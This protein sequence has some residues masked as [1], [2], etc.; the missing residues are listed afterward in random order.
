[1]DHYNSQSFD[2]VVKYFENYTLDQN[3]P[4]SYWIGAIGLNH[5]DDDGNLK[6]EMSFEPPSE[7][8]MYHGVH[9][10]YGFQSLQYLQERGLFKLK[11]TNYG[12][13]SKALEKT[14]YGNTLKRRSLNHR[15]QYYLGTCFRGRISEDRSINRQFIF[16]DD[17]YQTL[18]DEQKIFF[19]NSKIDLESDSG[20][21]VYYHA[22]KGH[23]ILQN[24]LKYGPRGP[25]CASVKDETLN[26][27]FHPGSVRSDV[28][29]EADFDDWDIF[30]Y[31]PHNRIDGLE[32]STIEQF[33]SILKKYE[34]LKERG[35]EV[36]EEPSRPVSLLYTE[37]R[38]ETSPKDIRLEGFREEVFDWSQ[39]IYDQFSGKPLSVYIGHDKSHRSGNKFLSDIS[40]KSF[41]DI[42]HKTL[43]TIYKPFDIKKLDVSEIPEYKRPYSNQS[44]EFTYS[45]FLVPF[46]ENYTGYSM[47]F[48]DDFI[49][50]K[51]PSI[52]FY[53]VDP[54]VAVS[55]VQYPEMIFSETKFNGQQNVNY[56]KKLWSSLMIF[57]NSHPDCKILTPEIVNEKS[58]SWLHQFE[59][60]EKVGNI[61]LKYVHTEG[62]SG[63]SVDKDCLLIHY[64]RGGPWI[65]NMD[66]SDIKNLSYFE[67]YV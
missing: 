5:F 58:G 47:F 48:D 42:S 14:S 53:W 54:D 17:V 40:E 59:W 45:R 41:R 1:M 26:I 36:V 4:D 24:A 31:D 2:E 18:T 61:P 60:T 21:S 27:A 64:T 3:D 46:L 29:V 11:V 32:Y 50:I 6:E 12:E 16:L 56:P 28:I 63:E 62:H 66:V 30:L 57:N 35:D 38:L 33:I 44:T 23:W 49:F 15:T 19:D 9:R 7:G 51:D 65:E 8:K 55:C 37:G 39:K 67:K 10:G 13:L 43:D 25:V 22:V 52:L 20:C 34:F